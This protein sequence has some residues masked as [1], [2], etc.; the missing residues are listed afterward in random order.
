MEVPVI[1]MD[2]CDEIH[3]ADFINNLVTVLAEER[4]GLAV[5]RPEAFVAGTFDNA[6]A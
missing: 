1:S 3:E 2:F 5:R 4:L 6:P